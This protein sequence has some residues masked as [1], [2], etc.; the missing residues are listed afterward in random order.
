[1]EVSA[2][3]LTVLAVLLAPAVILGLVG[4]VRGYHM[5]LKIWKHDHREDDHGND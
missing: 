4:M 3:Q 2:E 1:M 5:H